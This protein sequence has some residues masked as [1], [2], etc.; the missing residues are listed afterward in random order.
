MWLRG[1]GGREDD[2]HYRQTRCI[3]NN[4]DRHQTNRKKTLHAPFPPRI[5]FLVS[6]CCCCCSLQAYFS[7]SGSA[8]HHPFTFGKWYGGSIVL[9]STTSSARG[10]GAA[11]TIIIDTYMGGPSAAFDSERA[12]KTGWH[13]TPPIATMTAAAQRSC[14]SRE[15]W[16]EGMRKGPIFRFFFHFRRLR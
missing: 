8:L 1:G 13:A 14:Q 6:F 3:Q 4:G 5:S 10:G 12:S 7:L 16:E 2:A 11:C 15:S 9:S